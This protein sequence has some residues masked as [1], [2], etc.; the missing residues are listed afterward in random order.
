MRHGVRD[1]PDARRRW[2][3][4]A[5][6]RRRRRRL[7]Q[8][9]GACRRSLSNRALCVP[10]P[11]LQPGSLLGPAPS[12]ADT[13]KWAAVSFLNKGQEV[14]LVQAGLG[15]RSD[16]HLATSAIFQPPP[17]LPPSCPART[18]SAQVLDASQASQAELNSGEG[19]IYSNIKV[20]GTSD[21]V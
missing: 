7:D 20:G 14:H 11:A 4:Q 21:W 17:T 1:A 6:P 3:E 8:Y 9:L 12:A 19:G 16:R 10:P 5:A 15:T 18:V 2:V 13:A